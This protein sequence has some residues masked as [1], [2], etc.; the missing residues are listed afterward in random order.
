MK[1]KGGLIILAAAMAAAIVWAQDS[2]PSE[3]AGKA[4]R[5]DKAITEINMRG[6][7]DNWDHMWLYEHGTTTRATSAPASEPAVIPQAAGNGDADTEDA[8]TVPQL[9]VAQPAPPGDANANTVITATDSQ[10]YAEQ[11]VQV[12]E[13][14][15]ERPSAPAS[16]PSA[17]TRPALAKMVKQLKTRKAAEALIAKIGPAKAAELD[18]IEQDLAKLGPGVMVPLKLAQGSESFEVRQRAAKMAARLR[19]Q[20]ALGGGKPTAEQAKLIEVMAGDDAPARAA[21][22]D[23]IAGL[24]EEE[25]TGFLGECLA[26]SQT[27]VRQKAIEGLVNLGGKGSDEGPKAPAVTKLLEQ[28]LSDSDR[29]IRLLAVGALAEIG[30]IEPAKVAPLLNDESQEVRL[31]VIQALGFSGKP[32]SRQVLCPLLKDPNWR[33]RAATLEALGKLMAYRDK[34]DKA[35][36]EDVATLLADDDDYVRALAGK[37]MAEWKVPGTGEKLFQ[38][39]QQ[40]KIGAD[41]GYAMLAKLK[42]QPALDHIVAIYKAAKEPA[43]R[44]KFLKLLAQWE[45]APQAAAIIETALK[46]DSLKAQRAAIVELV[47]YRSVEAMFAT[48]TGFLESDDA[49]LAQ[50]AW[51]K[52]ERQFDNAK[53]LPADL[54]QR[55][56]KSADARR[57]LY[58]LKS[59]YM[60]SGD[61]ALG[62]P[63]LSGLRHKDAT[64]VNAS[65]AMTANLLFSDALGVDLP[66]R[67]DRMEMAYRSFGKQAKSRSFTLSADFVDALK[68]AHLRPEKDV[69]LRAAAVLYRSQKD[70][71]ATVQATL[72]AHLDDADVRLRWAAL[73]GIVEQPVPFLAQLNLDALSN[74]KAFRSIAV[75]IMAR[76][77]DT[78]HLG[79]LMKLA[80][81]EKNIGYN[82]ELPKAL[83]AS[84]D[85]KAIDLLMK[86]VP[87]DQNYQ[88]QTISERI[89]GMSGPGPVKFIEK[90]WNRLSGDN[91]YQRRELVMVLVTLKDPSAKA[92]LKKAMDDREMRDM[93]PQIM[94][95]LAELD[96]AEALVTLR[97]QLASDS[98][99][100]Q[101]AAAQVLAQTKLTPELM[102]LVIEVGKKNG[103]VPYSKSAWQAIAKIG[104]DATLRNGFLPVLGQLNT[105]L[106]QGVAMRLMD[107]AKAQ[108]LPALIKVQANDW[109]AREGIAAVIGL[110]TAEDKASRPDVA[111]LDE[112]GLVNVLGAAGDW[113]EAPSVVG[114]YLS[115]KRAAVAAAARRGLALWVLSHPAATVQ[116][117]WRDA[118]VAGV[119]ADEPVTAYLSAEALAVR[120][121]DDFVKLPIGSIKSSTAKLRQA[122]AMGDKLTPAHRQL[123]ARTLSDHS[124]PTAMELAAV[125][126]AISWDESYSVTPDLPIGLPEEVRSRLAKHVKSSSGEEVDGFYPDM[127]NKAKLPALIARARKDDTP[128]FLRLAA[129]GMI[130]KPEP[131]DMDRLLD[132]Q[133]AELWNVGLDRL[134]DAAIAWTGD[135]PDAKLLERISAKSTAGLIVAAVAELKWKN[136]AAHKALLEAVM[137]GK[138]DSEA[139]NKRRELAARVLRMTVQPADAAALKDAIAKIKAEDWNQRQKRADLIVLLGT[140]D[141]KTAM[142]M[143]EKDSDDESHHFISSEEPQAKWFAPIVADEKDWKAPDEDR[144]SSGPGRA[145]PDF[146]T[147]LA[148][149]RTGGLAKE[150]AILL[151]P[152]GSRGRSNTPDVLWEDGQ[153]KQ[154]L[155]ER[156]KELLEPHD[157]QR[158]RIS[159]SLDEE[160]GEPA[161]P[162]KMTAEQAHRQDARPVGLYLK[163]E[164][165]IEAVN[166]LLTKN[167][168]AAVA[169][170]RMLGDWQVKSARPMLAERLKGADVVEAAWSLA[171]LEGP[172]AVETI[173]PA[174][175]AQK[176]F[177]TRVR[178]ACLLRLIG[179]EA[180][181]ADIERALTLGTARQYRMKFLPQVADWD[182]R[183]MY[184]RRA[185]RMRRGM[186]IDRQDN[187]EP[188]RNRV[189]PWT[190]ALELAARDLRQQRQ[191]RLALLDE[192]APAAAT[193]TSMPSAATLMMQPDMKMGL[194]TAG[195]SRPVTVTSRLPL[196][197]LAR[198][199]MWV[200]LEWRGPVVEPEMPLPTSEGYLF[201]RL[202]E[203]EQDREPLFY[204]QFADQAKDMPELADKWAAWWAANKSLSREQ[205][206]RQGLEQAV[207]E[208]TH[209]KWWHRMRAVRRLERL[210]GQAVYSP[211]LNVF[212]MKA[213]QGLQAQWRAKIGT[214]QADTDYRDPRTALIREGL[215]AGVL[216]R[217]DVNEF[218]GE[219]ADAAGLRNL[220]K[221]A[222]F[223]KQPLAEAA[224]IQLETWPDQ[225]ALVRASLGWQFSPRRDLASWARGRLE[226]LTGRQRL[227]YT[228]EDAKEAATRPV[229]ATQTAPAME[230]GTQPASAMQ[231]VP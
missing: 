44:M 109:A 161:K 171:V 179:S 80:S 185:Y 77:Q 131:G 69:Q 122:V 4:A 138:A 208:L 111:K 56:L 62:G 168:D 175:E 18:G 38:L 193:A 19:W 11:I 183:N 213:W 139:A 130:G 127:F 102:A 12:N 33:V 116:A 181:A 66:Y 189:M 205:W 99:E 9:E 149:L 45:E 16:Q 73:A 202:C 225:A 156:V 91:S 26:D 119:Q 143:L 145:T 176:D 160:S 71:S 182:D 120:W 20:F 150:K 82:E 118:F 110:L 54:Q 1:I 147:V 81:A 125:S 187:G 46:D 216:T 17:T 186:M 101:T 229:P 84:G 64:V 220:V 184:M 172:A 209:A 206:W 76:S 41:E 207:G 48:L 35:T 174:Y 228:Q 29:N 88:L 166:P 21:K 60:Q 214:A 57:F 121:K 223:A 157:K 141:P 212:D 31:T 61:D 180:G 58:G 195:L 114:P 70:A 40:G 34:P 219:T 51:Q 95:R 164:E 218:N 104:D 226:M 72:R 203:A 148:E 42:Y 137:F 194:T 90:A 53:S 2:Q 169:A 154:A 132:A 96:P 159:E 15:A 188:M 93:Q 158:D 55:L 136:A 227:V 167:G 79:T 140:A 3:N 192:Q 37:V 5:E 63:I 173:R 52:L 221:L 217:Q 222:G 133:P 36:A 196:T 28:S 24:V 30:A 67:R 7:A 6:A 170:V 165:I 86:R 103:G 22:V 87:K 199:N 75:Q 32:Q 89:K 142:A 163:D 113:E 8:V 153:A 25:Y 215:R 146:T 85:D 115:D 201:A 128:L 210:T 74:D 98:S 197:K 230:P 129:A 135:K 94:A 23:E 178:L 134:A 162:I 106:Q 200:Q 65:L 13:A 204:V 78:K 107:A 123:V 124:G 68:K 43:S 97:K 144:L 47:S 117:A 59:L 198:E 92:L 211:T 190:E 83:I 177:G 191:R 105:P 100:K 39:M 27:Y 50:A 10:G 108:D 152:W 126:A 49:A 151:P 112:T 224:L 14:T 231:P 155:A